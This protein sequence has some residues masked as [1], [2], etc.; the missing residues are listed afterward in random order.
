[1]KKE[2]DKDINNKSLEFTLWTLIVILLALG[3]ILNIYFSMYPAQIRIVGW[4]ILVSMVGGLILCTQK[5]QRLKMLAVEAKAELRKVI[6]PTRQETIRSTISVV[7][8]VLA[9]GF[10]LWAIDVLLMWIIGKLTV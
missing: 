1:M 6:W 5:G 10:A 7:L 8:M 3:V 2:S 9:A 4:L